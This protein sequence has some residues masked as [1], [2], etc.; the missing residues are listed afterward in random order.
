MHISFEA[1]QVEEEEE[2]KRE[3]TTR[4]GRSRRGEGGR[5]EVKSSRI[6]TE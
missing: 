6:L 2:K 3:E 4:G 1:G 5:V